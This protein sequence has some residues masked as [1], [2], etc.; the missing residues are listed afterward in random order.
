MPSFLRK[1]S[2]KSLFDLGSDEEDFNMT[3]NGKNIEEMDGEE[4]NV[5][6]G[7]MDEDGMMDPKL[8]SKLNFSGFDSNSAFNSEGKKK[9]KKEI[10]EELVKKSKMHKIESQ[11]EQEENYEL[12]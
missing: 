2:K 11:R 1:R 5:F 4:I 6:T 10:M 3:H 7:D 9:T 8:I 12:K